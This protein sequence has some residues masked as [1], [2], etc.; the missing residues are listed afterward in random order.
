M[1]SIQLVSISAFCFPWLVNPTVTSDPSTAPDPPFNPW[2]PDDDPRVRSRF[3]RL[4]TP[5][6][7]R[8]VEAHLIFGFCARHLP[9]ILI[10][11]SVLTVAYVGLLI[12]AGING[13]HL[14]T[15]AGTAGLAGAG[16]ATLCRASYRQQAIM[17]WLATKLILAIICL[18]LIPIALCLWLAQ[19]RLVWRSVFFLSLV[20]LPGPEFSSRLVSVQRYLTLARLV[21]SVPLVLAIIHLQNG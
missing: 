3:A 1:L 12:W 6:R 7:V 17:A 13:E 16:I 9:I 15:G 19:D 4:E 5:F 10:A 14:G 8:Q 2:N 18:N 11:A 21:L 20:W